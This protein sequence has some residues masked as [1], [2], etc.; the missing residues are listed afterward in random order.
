MYRC[1]YNLGKDDYDTTTILHRQNW[2]QFFFSMYN[3]T[4]TNNNMNKFGFKEAN[5]FLN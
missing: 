3:D 2:I 5:I 1:I 4:K